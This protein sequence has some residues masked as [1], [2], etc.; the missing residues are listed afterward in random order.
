MISV[1]TLT[2]ELDGRFRNLE[3]SVGKYHLSL[4]WEPAPAV[5]RVGAMLEAYDWDNRMKALRMLREFAQA[6]ADE[7]ALE[8]DIVPLEAVTNPE[9]AEA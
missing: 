4:R 1:E 3:P 6:H 9:Y 5:V 7:F 2:Y 8:Y